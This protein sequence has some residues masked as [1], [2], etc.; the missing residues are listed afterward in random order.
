[1]ERALQAAEGE[2]GST[3][4]ASKSGVMERG[5]GRS[6]ASRAGAETV[7]RM[8]LCPVVTV[9]LGATGSISAAVGSDLVHWSRRGY[10][11]GRKAHPWG[12]VVKGTCNRKA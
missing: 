11:I 9:G 7:R 6:G 3:T 2:R 1:M 8:A 4:Q 10:G 5:T 12:S